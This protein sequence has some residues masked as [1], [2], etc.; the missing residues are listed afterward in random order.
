M[1]RGEYIYLAL[2]GAIIALLIVRAINAPK[3][4]DW[5]E[6]LS[7]YYRTPY[8]TELLYERL[9]DL[10]SGRITTS[11]DRI[12]QTEWAR[13]AS[14]D[15][16]TH[17]FLMAYFE[18]DGVE[19]NA[20]LHLAEQGDDV[21]I[22]ASALSDTLEDLLG[23][24]ITESQGLAEKLTVRFTGLPG[25][26]R[27]YTMDKARYNTCF[28]SLPVGSTMLA[29]NGSSEP[30]FVHIP[31][32]DGHIW[33]CTVP[34]AF[35]NY[36]LLQ[37][38]NEEF[39]AT[40]LSYLPKDHPVLWNEH[41]KVGR[42]GRA[43]PLRWLLANTATR[44]AVYLA[45]ALVLVYMLFRVKR[46]QRAVPIVE[47]LRNSSRE[48]VQTIGHLYFRKGDHADL[49]RKMILYFKEELRQR[50]YLRQFAN[51]AA[52]CEH[53]ALK[54]GLPVAEVV[55]RLDR[56]TAIESAKRISEEQLLALN[57][58]LGDLRARL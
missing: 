29:L 9:P 11:H 13:D 18:P 32:G 10:F 47:P 48:F 6:N 30:V 38:P 33:L 2:C 39:I 19:T 44:W 7:R 53:L 41:Y 46:E 56:I 49:A 14:Q 3:P 12:R 40:A 54:L 31:Y 5:S 4:V 37:H 20:L 17:M 27:P 21:F 25:A 57:N 34:L 28:D 15:P 58:E 1:K 8:G 43:T 22:A 45:M 50:T 35:T 26:T 24:D 51:D 23:V 55:Q 52:T 16:R 36:Q 42:L